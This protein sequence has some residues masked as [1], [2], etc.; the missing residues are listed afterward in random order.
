MLLPRALA[1]GL[2]KGFAFARPPNEPVLW[3]AL[4]ATRIGTQTA[5]PTLAEVKKWDV[6]R[7][8]RVA[9]PRPKF[10][11]ENTK[12]RKHERNEKA[13][14]A[15]KHVSFCFPL[16]FFVFSYFRVFVMEFRL[17]FSAFHGSGTR[18]TA[19]HQPALAPLI[20]T[21]RHDT[22]KPCGR[23]IWSR[24]ASFSIWQ[25]SRVDAG[26]VGRPDVAGRPL[27]GGSPPPSRQRADPACTRR[28]RSPSPP[29]RPAT[30]RLRGPGPAGRNSRR[31]RSRLSAPVCSSTMSSGLRR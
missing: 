3:G 10:H 22:Q 2:A 25:Y 12:V 28:C 21:G 16:V 13:A 18:A 29:A 19:R 27:C 4:T 14:P 23:G 11:H 9:E 1:I 5:F 31:S 7:V 6:S 26:E 8:E 17:T 20:L 15:T 24:L 30:A